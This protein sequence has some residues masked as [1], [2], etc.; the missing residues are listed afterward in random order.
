MT[1]TLRF[2]TRQ[3]LN[4][5]AEFDAVYAARQ[6]ASDGCLRVYGLRNTRGWTRIGLSVG[7]KQGHAVR[8]ARLKRL[9][10]EAFRL[11]QHELPVGL[12]V[13]LIPQV[14]TTAG[15]TEFRS[16]LAKLLRQ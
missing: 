15:V 13:V 14:G 2:Q 5:P 7:R 12:D 10:R 8:R 9:L 3:R 1:H 6:R 4:K 16:S 11:S